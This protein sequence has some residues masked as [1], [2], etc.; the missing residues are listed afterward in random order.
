VVAGQLLN[1]FS[2]PLGGSLVPNQGRY[3]LG[4]YRSIR[5]IGA[6]EELGENIAL[7]R[8][9]LRHFLSPELDMNLLDLFTVRRLQPRIFVDTGRVNDATGRVYDVGR[10][11]VG[12]GV[13]L[14][15]AYE[16]LGFFPAAAYVEIATRLDDGAGQGEVQFLFGTRQ[17]F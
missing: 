5:G 13:G 3:S 11:A 1:G 10:F 7:V 15:A 16:F 17:P 4:G 9:E 2:E 8:G 6:E 12:A 14:G